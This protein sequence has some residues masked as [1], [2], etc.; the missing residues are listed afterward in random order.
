MY[1][2]GITVP[3]FD[4]FYHFPFFIL[5]FLKLISSFFLNISWLTNHEGLWRTISLNESESFPGRL[6]KRLQ[7]RF[8]NS[9][10]EFEIFLS[11]KALIRDQ[12]NINSQ[13]EIL[14]LKKNGE[15]WRK[16][17]KAINVWNRNVAQFRVFGEMSC[18]GPLKALLTSL[19]MRV[20]IRE[21]TILIKGVISF[22]F[23]T[24]F[25]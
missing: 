16:L 7:L 21:L 3:Y 19:K 4:S 15:V 11:R 12:K 23:S 5:I 17:I 2:L 8:I 9:L 13:I 1:S 6:G 22:A 10:E 14:W 24:F 20:S 25:F 18:Y